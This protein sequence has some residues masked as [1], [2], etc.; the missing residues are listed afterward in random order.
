MN[1]KIEAIG[2]TL[3]VKPHGELDQSCAEKLRNDIDN[4]FFQNCS[5]NLVLDFADVSFMD[6]SGIGVIIGRYKRVKAL[7]G[8][9][10][11]IRPQPQ[12][13]KLLELSGIKKMIACSQEVNQ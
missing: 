13:D 9:T 7:G 2:S 12:V 8:K 3:V 1:L 11:L 5:K 4:A 6:S 10:M